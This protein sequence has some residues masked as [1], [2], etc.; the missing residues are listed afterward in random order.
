MKRS[1][2]NSSR[3]RAARFILLGNAAVYALGI[4]GNVIGLLLDLLRVPGYDPIW[5]Y[6]NLLTLGFAVSLVAYRFLERRPRVVMWGNAAFGALVLTVM[7]AHD[8]VVVGSSRPP[9]V[10]AM[11][12]VGVFAMGLVLGFRPALIYA[13]LVSL[14]SAALGFLYQD[15]GAPFVSITLAYAMTL[16]AW[17]IRRMERDLKTSEERFGVV[18]RES[19]DVILI[20]SRD[21]QEIVRA[22]RAAQSVLGYDPETLVGER[23]VALCAP[24]ADQVESDF[25]LGLDEASALFESHKFM[26]ADGSICP[27]DMTATR[28]P[29]GATQMTLVTLRDVADRE[30][31]EQELRLY[32]RQLEELVAERTAALRARNE[33]LDAFAHTVAHDLKSPL[34]RLIGASKI[35]QSS[36]DDLSAEERLYYLEAIEEGSYRMSS[37]IEELLL[38]AGVRQLDDV[39]LIP[40]DM[41]AVIDEAEERLAY[42]IKKYEAEIRKPE[43]W[44]TAIGYAPW[45]EEIWVNYLSNAIKYGGVPPRVELGY[46][47]E[48]GKGHVRFWVRDNGEGLTDEQMAQLF[49]PFMR[50]DQT[51]AEGDGLGLSIVRRIVDKLGGDVQVESTEGEGSIFSFSL[52]AAPRGDA[53]YSSLKGEPAA[54]N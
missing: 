10:L 36:H 8:A 48:E 12:H 41:A 2:A 11:F 13:T 31:T 53:L 30:A 27:M 23:F 52:P 9:V 42:L 25:L 37:I 40:L 34:T 47:I 5:F 19:L 1:L 35:L 45:V 14:L 50:I 51:R 29:W 26:R 21:T 3:L 18:F 46:E 28:I 20:V 44:P 49:V 6:S 17:L 7:L 16:P 54:R 32:R 43:T 33:E 15:L 4:L 24:S 39:T 38:L 22:N